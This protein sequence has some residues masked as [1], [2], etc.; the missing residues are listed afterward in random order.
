MDSQRSPGGAFIRAFAWGTLGLLLLAVGATGGYWF[1]GHPARRGV[2]PLD[3]SPRTPTAGDAALVQVTIEEVVPVETG[4]G[5]GT[6]VTLIAPDG[7]RSLPIWIGES[8]ALA[9]NLRLDGRVPERPLTHDLLDAI[10]AR[11]GARV[12]RV[13]IDDLDAGVFY[14][15]IHVVVE[16]TGRELVFDARPSDALIL[17][18]ASR[19]TSGP[20]GPWLPTRG[21]S[22]AIFIDSSLLRAPYEAPD[23]TEDPAPQGD[24][25]PHADP[26]YRPRQSRP[27]LPPGHPP[28]QGFSEQ[29]I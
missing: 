7:R 17:S 8:E 28:V 5:L 11:W 2:S 22:P 18:K 16:A 12:T 25:S 1:A 6:A 23:T 26:A 9:L 4:A 24:G 21:E 20:P 19:G 14:G 27:P 13:V 29:G 15:R 3:R 10:L